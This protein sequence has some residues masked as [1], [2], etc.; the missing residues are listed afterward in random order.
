M[1]STVTWIEMKDIVLSEMSMAQKHKYHMLSF[2]SISYKVDL[3]GTELRVQE[4]RNGKGMSNRNRDA[5]GQKELLPTFSS[6]VRRLWLVPINC[7]KIARI[8]NGPKQNGK[9]E[10]MASYLPI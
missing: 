9:Y 10:V 2:I 4:G 1:P 6:M 5:P 8:V 3:S 7:F